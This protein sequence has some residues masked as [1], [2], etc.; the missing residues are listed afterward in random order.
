MK[1]YAI[2][3]GIIATLVL[4]SFLIVEALGI[5]ILVDPSEYLDKGG[6]GAALLGGGLLLADVFIPIPSSVIMIA[7]GAVFGVVMGTLISL[8]SS[9]GGA[10]IGWWVG[11]RGS[12]W[13]RRVI[14]PA[15]Q[16]RANALLARWGVLAIIVSRLIPIIAETVAIMSGTTDLGWRKVLLATTAGTIPAALIYAIAGTVT[17]DLASGFLVM[18]AVVAIAALAWLV[19]NRLTRPGTALDGASST[20]P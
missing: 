20:T 13:L 6:L 4:I 2:V 1:T 9:V 7:H 11:K 19:G 12:G 3:A 10:M 5:P 15:E 18:L 14:S 8:V 17:T 16:A